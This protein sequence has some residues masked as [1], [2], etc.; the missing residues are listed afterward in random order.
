MKQLLL[1]LSLVLVL[2][3]AF[4]QGG[5][6][7]W[8]QVNLQTASKGKDVF[9]DHFKPSSYLSFQLNE[10]GMRAM[11]KNA[12]DEANVSGNR[13]SFIMSIPDSKGRMQRF[14]VVE[15]SVMQKGLQQA[16]PEIRSYAGKGIDD[17]TANIRFDMTPLGFH[18]TVISATRNTYYVNPVDE[19]NKVYLVYDRNMK[20]SKQVFDCELE[21]VVSN[22]IQGTNFAGK[23]ANTGKLR[24]Y[25]LALCTSGE[26]SIKAINGATGTDAEKKNIVLA[27]LNTNVTAANV[28]FENE[29][30][31]RLQ[32]I[33][34]EASIIYLDSLTDPWATANTNWNSTTQ[35]TCTNVIGSANYDVGHVLNYTSYNNGNAGC[36]GCVC[37]SSSKGSGWTTYQ[38]IQ[39]NYFIID[40]WTHELGHQF[41]ANHTFT[42][43]AEGTTAQVEPGSGTTIMGYAGITGATDVQPHSDPYF[44]GVSINQVAT[45]IQTGGT[46]NSCGT[47]TSIT[48]NIPTANAGADYTIPKSTPFALTGAATDADAGDVLTYCWE[49][50]DAY[51]TSSNSNT[52]PT[53]TTTKGP[54]FRSFNPVT[55]TARLFPKLVTILDSNNTSKWE[56]L[57]S[58]ARTLNFRLTVRDNHPGDGANQTDDMLVT[59][60]SAA[61]P[62]LVTAPNTAVN[63]GAGT[64]QT[65]TWSV[66]STNLS[67]ISCANVKISLSTDGGQTFSTV[68]AASTA[69]DGSEVV[70]LPNVTSSTCRIKVEAIGNIFFDI[71]NANFSIGSCGTPGSL[72]SSAVT[73]TTATVSWGAVSGASS[74]DVDY[75]LTSSGTWTNAATATAATSVNL[76]GLVPGNVY[77]WRVKNNCSFG[78]SSYATAQFTSACSVAPSGLNV[79]NITPST[80]KLNWSATASAISYDVDYKANSSS[81]WINAATATVSTNVSISSLSANTLYDYRVRANCNS[82]SSGYTAAQFTTTQSLVASVVQN[83]AINCNGGTTTVTVSATGGVA[84]YTGT[85]TFTV[86]AGT[87]SYTVSDAASATST[88]GITVAEPSAINVQE[89]HTAISCNGGNSSVTISATGGTAPYTGTGTFNQAAGSHTYTVTDAHGCSSGITVAISQPSAISVQE[90]HTSIACNGSSSSVTISATGG[91]S[92]YTGT[93]IFNQ[94]AG[95]NTY[96]VSDANGCSSSLDVTISQ[97]ALL[98]A[99]ESH[100]AIACNNSS[101]NVTISATGGTAPYSGTGTFVQAAGTQSYT[102]TD[103]NG[104]STSI[105]VTVTQPD[106]L[107]V[108]ESHTAITCH[109]S[110]SSVTIS[111]TGGSAPYTGTG[112]F[113]QAAGTHEYTVTDASGCVS[114]VSITLSEPAAIDVQESHTAITCHGGNASVTIT[115]SG[116]TGT[117]TGTGTFSQAAG[118]HTYVVSD[119][120]GCSSS[121]DVTVSEPAAINIQESHTAIACNGGTSSVTISATG[122]TGTLTGTGTFSQS[123]GTQTYVVSDAN[124]CSASLDVIISQ[125]DVLSAQENHTNIA[126]NGGS[127]SVTVAATGGTLPYT[128]TGTFNQ[129]AGTQTYNISDANGCASSVTVILTQPALLKAKESH[130]LVSCVGGSSTVTITGQGGTTPYTG[131]GTFTQTASTKSYP[132]SDANGCSASVSVK[133]LDGTGTKPAKPGTITQEKNGSGSLNICGG[134]TFK[135]HITSVPTATSYNWVVP[136]NATLI[137]ATDSSAIVTFSAVFT[138]GILSVSAV[139]SCGTSNASTITLSTAPVKPANISGPLTVTSRQKG[140][141]YSVVSP[142]PAYTY[143]WSVP[144]SVTIVSG[145]GTSTLTVNWGSK[146]GSVSVKASNGCGTTTAKTIS[147]TVGAAKEIAIQQPSQKIDLHAYPNPVYTTATLSFNAAKGG[148]Y[149]V[150]IAELNGKLISVINGASVTGKNTVS[151]NL[152]NYANGTYL[153]TLK[154]ETGAQTIKLTKEK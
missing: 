28:V 149:S 27:V 31:V 153:V 44:H 24:T 45:Y 150:E 85:G 9:A 109:G 144:S 41:G 141:I 3:T 65:V 110:T 95:T 66:N 62:F 108:Q 61:G 47:E 83:G 101:S 119:A 6:N 121:I 55:S 26:Y 69:N 93:G 74:Y 143:T 34:N 102:V 59:V 36:I 114:T 126:C 97:P 1:A 76:S 35:T 14:R 131:V 11:L 103:A 128:G 71:S 63:W 94:A 72:A 111:A 122:G 79:T 53:S 32:L 78:T 134:G 133:V 52:Y 142:D 123:A 99:H 42:H 2:S 151:I 113:T 67:P 5:V 87:Y 51:G 145:Q 98:V 132:I 138:T 77:D 8:R 107:D 135:F 80:A 21:S 117:L 129:V 50:I 136:A 91:T 70:T 90:S 105:D 89:S 60:S 75:K 104:C 39:G 64:Q 147:V 139:N 37:T 127:S 100:S 146:S 96:N 140:V 17:P 73:G 58:V 48:N 18:A 16:H 152:S 25:R 20:D 54:I 154:T 120:N 29:F 124:S 30:G 84:P 46:G 92:P 86:G 15:A 10:S 68:L 82:G 57:S 130:T 43:K 19:K 116:G 4:S 115:A 38:Q 40:Y 49:Q 137:S 88:T 112:T 118:T 56:V 81:T 7:L 23:S 106:P 33:N 12:P 148:K 22:N 13:S 125:P